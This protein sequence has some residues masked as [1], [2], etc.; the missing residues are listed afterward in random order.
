M[1]AFGYILEL[2]PKHYDS[3]AKLQKINNVP[4]R[5]KISIAVALIEHFSV[6]TLP[7]MLFIAFSSYNII[8]GIIW[9]YFS[10][11]RRLDPSLY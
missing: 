9:T 2:M 7:V 1:A 6:I 5:F 3:D 10:N 11:N 8:L 4:K